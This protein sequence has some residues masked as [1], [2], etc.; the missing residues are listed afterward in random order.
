MAAGILVDSMVD[1]S[2]PKI[3]GLKLRRNAA[4]PNELIA[5]WNK[6]SMKKYKRNKKNE[7][8]IKSSGKVKAIEAVKS[9][10]IVWHVYR[11]DAKGKTVRTDSVSTLDNTHYPV[12]T[13]HTI[14]STATKV[15]FFIKPESKTYSYETVKTTTTGSGKKKKKTKTTTTHTGYYF[16]GVKEYSKTF[17]LQ[18]V[19]DTPPSVQLSSSAAASGN[20]SDV[21]L[22]ITGYPTTTTKIQYEIADGQSSGNV[23]LATT[24]G[25]YPSFTKTLC[26]TRV[27]L[28]TGSYTGQIMARARVQYPGGLWG[29]WSNWSSSVYYYSNDKG[30]SASELQATAIS[31]T[32]ISLTWKQFAA[33][34]YEIQYVVNDPTLFDSTEGT[35]V[36]QAANQGT[37]KI[38]QQLES[39]QT[40]YF[41]IRGSY[42]GS[43]TSWFPTSS[44]GYISVTLGLPPGIPTTYSLLNTLAVGETVRLYWVHNPRDKSTQVKAMVQLLFE[45][46]SGVNE[47]YVVVNNPYYDD[48]IRKD[49]NL[50]LEID[51]GS[52]LTVYG[53]PENAES[54]TSPISV[55]FSEGVSFQWR[56]KT[57]GIVPEY[58]EYSVY[59]KITVYAQP[60]LTLEASSDGVTWDNPTTLSS[61]PLWLRMSITPRTQAPIGFSVN[62]IAQDSYSYDMVNGETGYVTA[63]ETIFS[64]YV[65]VTENP[66]VYKLDSTKA[67]LQ[68]GVSY[69]ITTAVATDIGLSAENDYYIT[70]AWEDVGMAPTADVEADFDRLICMI[71]PVC[72]ESDVD[73]DQYMEYDE[74]NDEWLVDVDSFDFEPMENVSLAVYRANSDGSFT[75]IASGLSNPPD[76]PIVDPHPTLDYVYYRVVSTYI[77]TGQQ[78]YTDFGPVEFD[79]P[80]LVLDWDQEVSLVD[81]N[82]LVME[83]EGVIPIQAY[84]GSMV[85]LPF[86]VD[87]S[88]GHSRD[89]ELIEYIGRQRPV[90]YYGTQL[91][92]SF[93]YKTEIPVEPDDEELDWLGDAIV[94]GGYTYT[95]GMLRQLSRYMG[96]VYVRDNLARSGFW[97]HV[98]VSME[99]N[100]MAHTVPVTLTVT[101]VEGG[102]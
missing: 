85:T 102:A 51:T 48:E 99:I 37:T 60:E 73:Y 19:L 14:D 43:Y 42:Q 62:V 13:T 64:D 84:Q 96:P 8:A 41:R 55:S 76:E 61:F 9:F 16:T 101:P 22:T 90:G 95:I 79:Q 2:A 12:S 59:R 26:N 92:E 5:E 88:E 100:H 46:V 57:Q 77:P 29:Q 21:R 65:N 56:V 71:L 23:I 66:Y 11:V 33:D 70:P 78:E 6:C 80:G 69:L 10:R 38:I 25:G 44:T 72:F 39:G 83:E 49:E 20:G 50:Y 53:S 7:L 52:T 67:A 40:Y 63:G 4:N 17:D 93:S 27:V 87:T 31:S 34:T 45:G 30:A 94:Y 15:T 1:K 86:N 58:S 54:K 18:S 74:E 36:T 75:E 89:S 97:A 47:G 68:N 91:G 32:S 24:D 98:D 3:T 35:T 81:V 82:D 28:S